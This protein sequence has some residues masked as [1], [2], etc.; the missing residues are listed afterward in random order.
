MNNNLNSSKEEQSSEE[1]F[2]LVDKK[3]HPMASMDIGGGM[4]QDNFYKIPQAAESMSP[5]KPGDHSMSNPCNLMAV[6]EWSDHQ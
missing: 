3:Y 5:W 6:S 2:A 1:H 4:T